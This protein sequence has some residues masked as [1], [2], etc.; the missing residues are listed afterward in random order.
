[1]KLEGLVV[2][3]KDRDCTMFAEISIQDHEVEAK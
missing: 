2:M 3:S 1:M